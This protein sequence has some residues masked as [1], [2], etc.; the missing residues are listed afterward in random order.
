VKTRSIQSIIRYTIQ[1]MYLLSSPPSRDAF[2]HSGGESLLCTSETV[3]LYLDVELSRESLP[4]TEQKTS[5][6]NELY[7]FMAPP[8]KVF[9]HREPPL[10]HIPPTL[11]EPLRVLNVLN[12]FASGHVICTGR[13]SE[14]PPTPT[15]HTLP[16]APGKGMFRLDGTESSGA[17]QQ[18]RRGLFR[19]PF[20]MCAGGLPDPLW[21]PLCPGIVNSL[22]L[23]HIF[24]CSC[25]RIKFEIIYC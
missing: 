20:V 1:I 14:H 13:G 3:T 6:A 19:S 4:G 5:L 25:D 15:P 18:E 10:G 22:H 11:R 17:L 16:H 21:R 7:W 23:F 9:A 24:M 12:V 2:K 8:P